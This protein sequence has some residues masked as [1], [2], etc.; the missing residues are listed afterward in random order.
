MIYDYFLLCKRLRFDDHIIVVPQLLLDK[1]P[2]LRF[3]YVVR[4]RCQHFTQGFD[5]AMEVL[6]VAADP[7]DQTLVRG[8]ALVAKT[9]DR[10]RIETFDQFE[11]EQRGE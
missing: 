1:R 2:E 4:K 8:V 9:G 5:N 11:L 6:V 10:C 3:R 7:D